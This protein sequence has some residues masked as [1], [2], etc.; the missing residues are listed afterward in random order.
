MVVRLMDIS[1]ITQCDKDLD[2]QPRA[3]WPTALPAL[4]WKG[5]LL[6]GFSRTA[7]VAIDL[8]HVHRAPLLESLKACHKDLGLAEVARL[9][10]RL[11]KVWP[12][13][14]QE[15]KSGFLQ[16]YGLR[17]GDRLEQTLKRLARTP[18]EFQDWVDVK[19]CGA[20]ELAP[21]LALPAPGEFDPFLRALTS[22]GF[23]RSE[24]ARALELGCD[25]FLMGR[26]LNDILP[27]QNEG[28]AYLRQLEKW[29]RPNM[30]ITDEQWRE[31]VSQ[32][33]WPAQ[34]QAS[35]QRFGDQ[36][37]L[38]IKLRATSPQDLNKKLERMRSIGDSWHDR[39]ER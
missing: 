34:V 16:E 27:A 9:S 13:T 30:N 1:S 11:E 20:R 7:G 17:A 3:E 8:F 35:W 10:A 19:K 38:E 6:T 28:A 4:A 24:G 32:W 39:V 15:L 26:P 5:Q 37:G 22:M 2:F 29:R 33:P 36:S 21:L 18:P 14:F 31:T 25:L 12:E 23:S